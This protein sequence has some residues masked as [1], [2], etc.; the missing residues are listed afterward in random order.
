M[1]HVVRRTSSYYFVA[2]VVCC[3]VYIFLVICGHWC[4]VGW[5]IHPQVICSH[6]CKSPKLP[7][8]KPHWPRQSQHLGQGQGIPVY[9]VTQDRLLK[10]YLCAWNHPVFQIFKKE[11]TKQL[12]S[13]PDQ[14]NAPEFSYQ[15]IK[16]KVL[17]MHL[18]KKSWL[19]I[20]K[21]FFLVMCLQLKKLKIIWLFCRFSS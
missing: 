21:I 12:P 6:V 19:C 7:M 13:I 15:T 10:A 3:G 18:Q 8:H 5:G 11:C 4:V 9:A 14:K 17:V 1:V 2:T 20:C 16:S